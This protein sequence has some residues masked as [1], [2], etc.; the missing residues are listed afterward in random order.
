MCK[1]MSVPEYISLPFISMILFLVRTECAAS[2]S[3]ASSNVQTYTE[4]YFS[5]LSAIFSQSIQPMHSQLIFCCIQIEQV[6][7]FVF[8]RVR[9]QEKLSQLN[10]FEYK[11]EEE[12]TKQQRN[13][14]LDSTFSWFKLKWRA[15]CMH[16][17]A[18]ECRRSHHTFVRRRTE[19]VSWVISFLQNGTQ[20]HTA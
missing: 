16:L 7:A 19:Y 2:L 9:V 4:R 5:E 3:M 20:T 14:K 10:F 6:C 8:V 17:C 11:T 13:T 15:C 12:C 18:Q 1:I